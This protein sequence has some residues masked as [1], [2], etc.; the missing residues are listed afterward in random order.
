MKGNVW[1]C[2][3]SPD[4]DESVIYIDWYTDMFVSYKNLFEWH[5]SNNSL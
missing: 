1:K 5:I 2:T 4:K 3:H